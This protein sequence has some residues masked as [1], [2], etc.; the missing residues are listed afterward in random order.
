MPK[1]LVMFDMDGVLFD[2]MP[3]HAKSWAELAKAE[4]LGIDEELVYK[5]EGMTGSAFIK[6]LLGK[7]MEESECSQIYAR[8]AAIFDSYPQALPIPGALEAVEAVNE[9]GV[10]AIVVTGSGQKKL[11]SKIDRYFPGLF[12]TEWI[13]SAFDVKNSKPSPDPYLAGMRKAGVE[14][15]EA[16]VIENA[17][18]GIRSG[19]AAGC[20]TVAVNTGPLPDS[21]LLA[22]GADVLFHSM[23]ELAENIKSIIS[24]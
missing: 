11:M 4:N 20:Y 19:K 17:P 13:V 1:K 18:L 22:E 14:A 15:D 24:I 10:V 9:C 3:W 12:K 16:I 6:E 2:S 5:M 7:N 21:D 23:K 8:K